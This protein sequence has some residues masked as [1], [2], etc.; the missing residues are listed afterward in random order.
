MILQQITSGTNNIQALLEGNEDYLRSMVSAIVQATPEAEM[1]AAPG[2]EKG[3]WTS[4][5]QG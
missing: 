2:A 1:T 3:E 5:R 4:G